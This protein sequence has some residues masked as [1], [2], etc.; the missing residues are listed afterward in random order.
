MA[1]ADAVL[2]HTRQGKAR[3]APSRSLRQPARPHED[4]GPDRAWSGGAEPRVRLEQAQPHQAFRG[5]KQCLFV[6]PRGPAEQV[7][8]FCARCA[9]HTVELGQQQQLDLRVKQRD[10]TQQRIGQLPRGYLSRGCAQIGLKQLCDL[11]SRECVAG[12]RQ[13]PFAVCRRM[14]HGGEMQVGNIAHIHEAERD[15][16]ATGNSAFQKPLDEEDECGIAGPQNRSKHPTG[17]TTAS[18]KPLPSRV[19]KSHAA[20]SASVLDFAHALTPLPWRWSSW[21]R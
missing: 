6:R 19:M 3:F 7:F 12:N 2:D 11:L 17:F 21:S 13:E 9:L 20:R 16:R 18:S 15:V 1:N 5:C 14:R 8:G 4:C 10:Q